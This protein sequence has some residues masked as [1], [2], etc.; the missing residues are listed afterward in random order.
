MSHHHSLL[1]LF[2]RFRNFRQHWELGFEVIA[3]TWLTSWTTVL[4]L[5]G[6][7][8]WTRQQAFDL[9]YLLKQ[10]KW[11]QSRYVTLAKQ[12]CCSVAAAA[13]ASSDFGGPM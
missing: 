1:L 2:F 9:T 12:E 10:H 13:G 3:N 11:G 7:H 8:T 5:L 6:Q 4:A